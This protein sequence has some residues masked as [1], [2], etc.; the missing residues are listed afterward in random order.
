MDTI[1]IHLVFGLVQILGFCLLV[2]G[3]YKYT[4][5]KNALN[6]KLILTNAYDACSRATEEHKTKLETYVLDY[7]ISPDQFNDMPQSKV[8]LILKTQASTE[9]AAM[10][11]N[12]IAV[13]HNRK[14]YAKDATLSIRAR[15]LFKVV[16]EL[17]PQE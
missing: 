11:A 3:G 7:S 15:V 13:S 14:A 12:R 1:T 4:K 2:Y 6:K 5:A 9:L 17:E 10:L 16:N 8:E